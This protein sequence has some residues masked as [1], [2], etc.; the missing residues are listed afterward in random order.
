MGLVGNGWANCF[1]THNELTMGLPGKYPLAPS[2]GIYG[3]PGAW[4]PRPPLLRFSR[5]PLLI[6]LAYSLARTP[7]LA[8]HQSP[9]P[10]LVASSGRYSLLGTDPGTLANHHPLLGIDLGAGCVAHYLPLKVCSDSDGADHHLRWKAD[11]GSLAD[12]QPLGLDLSADPQPIT[13]P[14]GLILAPRSRFRCV[15][16]HC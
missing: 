9:R 6:L 3:V 7:P 11:L 2:V 1:R 5:R 15:L 14:L 4:C 16:H 10:D 12:H 8:N 13:Y